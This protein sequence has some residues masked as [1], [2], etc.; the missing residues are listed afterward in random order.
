MS[1]LCRTWH[2]ATRYFQARLY[3]DLIGDVV[4]ELSWG[5]RTNRLGGHKTLAVGTWDDGEVSLRQIAQRRCR[6]GYVESF[7]GTP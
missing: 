5:G 4:V 1:P 2:T 7:P 6:R 3:R